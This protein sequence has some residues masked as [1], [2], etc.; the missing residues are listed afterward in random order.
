MRDINIVLIINDILKYSISKNFYKPQNL[1]LFKRK[2]FLSYF[3]ICRWVKKFEVLSLFLKLFYL[4]NQN[5]I[6][7]NLMQKMKLKTK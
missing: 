1:S 5:L 4:L 6:K 7:I 3:V 2:L